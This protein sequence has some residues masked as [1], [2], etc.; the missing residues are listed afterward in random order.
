[1]IREAV[2][3]ITS[4]SLAAESVRAG[5][6]FSEN[7]GAVPL[8]VKGANSTFNTTDTHAAKK[9][10]PAERG[11]DR[12]GPEAPEL[13]P[14]Q[15]GRDSYGGKA[16]TETEHEQRQQAEHRRPDDADNE[17]AAAA[18]KDHGKDQGK[19]QQHERKTGG[20]GSS[21]GEGQQ[22]HGQQQ[23]QQQQGQDNTSATTTTSGNEKA[24]KHDTRGSGG[25]GSGAGAGNEDRSKQSGSSA[26]E[27]AGE[28]GASQSVTGTA[29]T[30]GASQDK[31]Q[32]ASVGLQ[33]TDEQDAAQAQHA[34]DRATSSGSSQ[35]VQGGAPGG[36]A[37]VAPAYV[38]YDVT[39]RAKPGG[40]KGARLTEGGE[41]D[42]D[43]DAPNASFNNE[44]GTENDPARLAEQKILLGRSALDSQPQQGRRV[45]G[46]LTDGGQYQAL[47]SDEPA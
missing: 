26:K 33:P 6:G 29:K 20:G 8:A 4:D 19:A 5:G 9:L 22:Q 1:M 47:S 32:A 45:G 38:K 44:I 25:S 37:G 13:E 3:P 40:P 18:A 34:A 30:E 39:E 11:S 16:R 27:G 12:P 21:G 2:G 28:T 14:L 41:L 36:Q 10:A 15:A 24:E 31:Q 35:V 7:R 23:R 42:N 43:E 46:E 17:A